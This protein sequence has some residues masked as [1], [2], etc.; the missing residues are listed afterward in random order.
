MGRR[1]GAVD[2]MSL[3]PGTRLGLYEVIAKLGEGGMGEVYRAR[4]TRLD[5]DV[6]LKIL[7]ESFATD[8]D[9]LMR[10]EREAKTLASLNHPNI[11]AIYGFENSPT[12]AGRHTNAL[13]MEL[14]EGEELSARIARGP[15]PLDEAL[16]IAKQIAEALEAAHEQGII[17]R[18]LKPANIKVRP[19]GT[20]KVLDFGL[21]KAMDQGSGIGDQRSGH[22]ANSPTITSPAM[23]MHGVIL[24]TAAYM[25][26]EQARG[27][28]VDIRTDIW[29]FGVVLYEMLTARRV[30]A[31][32]E[33]SD[34]LAAVLR[35][36]IDWTAL[37]TE[38]PASVRRLLRRCLEKE[39]GGRL[40]D[41][42]SARLEINDALA[43]DDASTTS[44]AIAPPTDQRLWRWMSAGLA[45]LA[46]GLASALLG[47]PAREITPDES[48]LRFTL[49]DDPNMQIR[50]TTQP[51]A[52]SPDGKTIVFSAAA[53]SNG[54]WARSLD[55]PTPRFL[56][57]TEGGLQPAIS[58]DGQSVA[59]VVSNHIIRKV[60][61]SGGAA[62]TVVSIDDVTAALAWAS[63]DS[64]LFEKIGSES[65]LHRVSAN[66]G[67]PELLIP[68][69]GDEQ[70]HYVPVV[71]RDPRLVFFATTTNVNTVRGLP[72]SGA[73]AAEGTTLSVFSLDDGRRGDLNLDGFRALGFIDSHL[74]Y[75]RDD[76]SLMA[77][78]FDARGLR[79]LGEPRLLEPRVSPARFGPSVTLSENGTLVSLP[80]VSPL[81]RL[82]L[83]DADGR[84]TPIGEA[85]A[86]D[87]PRFSSDGRRIA[88]GVAEGDGIDLW[89]VDRAT[90]AATRVTRGGPRSTKLESWTPDDRSLIH[91]RADE[92]WTVAINTGAEPQK[93]IALEGRLLGASLMTAGQ[94]VVVLRRIRDGQGNLHREELVRVPLTGDRTIVPIYS[95]RSSGNVLRGLD[96]RVSPDGR[97]VALH[98]R[99]DNQVHVRA[100]DGGAGLQVSDAGGIAPVWSHDSRSLYYRAPA[101]TMKATLQIIPTLAVTARQAVAGISS[102]ATLHDISADGRTFL[103]LV[104]VDAA[105]K[106]LV[107]VNW[108]AD[109]RRQLGA[110]E[111]RP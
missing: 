98:D 61:L 103:T 72:A 79:V 15:I 48:V 86:F 41:M 3:S 12:E 89:V 5:R 42:S 47:L 17:H 54:L 109:V 107:T 83:A 110:R 78:P 108:A 9:R 34:V 43:G 32:D 80:P 71:F 63:D 95:S 33:M 27:K 36:P 22:L 101:G 45:L 52:T 37:P 25:S 77:V 4:D 21:A 50:F 88:V 58:P 74:I 26:P 68:L 18:D 70:G 73:V 67:Q 19:D 100:V 96:P 1:P 49:V 94:S 20:V 69:S 51:F 66:G 7:P 35:Q 91:T 85:K 30:F 105:P 2:A 64:I 38:T 53:G 59:F 24:G 11:A 46:V 99:N 6:A 92:L 44:G 28:V 60:R 10:F 40:G 57:G 87:S 13:V 39:R 55:D 14:V 8:P 82:M 102:A 76:G 75:A 93:L 56:T 111:E 16:P 29:A 97:W 62:T 106:V 31:G 90:A 84:A 104:P 65:G 81:S 23:T